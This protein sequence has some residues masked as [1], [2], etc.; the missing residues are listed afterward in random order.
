[1]SPV[2]RRA[3]STRARLLEAGRVAFSQHG[4]DGANLTTDILEP[5]GVSVGSFY[6]QFPDKTELLIAILDEAAIQR[7]ASVLFRG[8]EDGKRPSFETDVALAIERLFVSMDDEA[9]VW[10]IQVRERIN[11]D[12]RIRQ[13]I[14]D[15]RRAWQQEVARFLAH[16]NRRD[17][18]ALAHAVEMIIIFCIGLVGAY[19][20]M[21]PDVRSARR[22]TLPPLVSEFLCSGVRPLLGIPAPRKRG[23]SAA[24]RND[25]VLPG[26]HFQ[27]ERRKA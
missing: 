26:R 5:A 18:D 20:D 13:R 19:L 1:M 23:Q 27:R 11:P 3:L 24:R 12:S 2:Q 4:H 7:K 14:L 17:D 9:H 22:L 10:R 8:Q 6:H 15:G 25:V 21:P 16:H